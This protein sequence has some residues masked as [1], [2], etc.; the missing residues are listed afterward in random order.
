MTAPPYGPARLAILALDAGAAV[1]LQDRYARDDLVEVHAGV[2]LP[3]STAALDIIL[4][5]STDASLISA[6]QLLATASEARAKGLLV[7]GVVT[8]S[9]ASA[10]GDHAQGPGLAALRGAVDM[11]V[12]LRDSALATELSDV[13]RGGLVP[14]LNRT[15]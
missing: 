15:N 13:L 3:P 2:R 14:A 4:F 12:I 11:L 1:L 7:A 5:L 6:D 10:E 9:L 8:G